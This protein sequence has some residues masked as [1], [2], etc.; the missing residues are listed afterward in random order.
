ML[1]IIITT[2]NRPQKVLQFVQ[3]LSNLP[4]HP[5]RIIVVDSSDD[6]NEALKQFPKVKYLKSSHKNQPYQRYLGFQNAE[7]DY[8]VF[9]DDDMEIV[10]ENFIPKLIEIFSEQK[11]TGV[12]IR[13]ENKHKDSLLAQMPSSRI[14]ITNNKLNLVKRWLSGWPV[15]KSGKFGFC[16]NRGK[17][18]F[19]GG[20]TEWLSGGAFAAS[21]VALFQN[22]NFQLFDIFEQGIGMGEDAIIGY[23]LSKQGALWYHDE[24][25]FLHNDQKDSTYSVDKYAYVQ[26]V[27]F[28]RLYLSLERQRLNQGNKLLACLHYHYYT[29]S[30]VIGYLMNF[31]IS[32][33]QSRK[34]MLKGA[35]AGWVKTFTF[36]FSYSERINNYWRNESDKDSAT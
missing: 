25:F 36:K 10:D 9:L 21:R 14:R 3:Q 31:A 8:L 22:F 11:V 35:L 1:D 27:I 4:I 6:D 7:S 28:S 13:F 17:Q 12:A 15:L 19:G 24:L 33:N 5:E 2:Y 26:R 34:D 32:P 30:R 18:L 20:K 29:F 16:G 23:S